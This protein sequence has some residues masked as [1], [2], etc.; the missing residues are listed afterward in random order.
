MPPPI[1]AGGVGRGGAALAST[2][3]QDRGGVRGRTLTKLPPLVPNTPEQA[4]TRQAELDALAAH[5]RARAQQDADRKRQQAAA[6]AAREANRPEVKA[7]RMKANTAIRRKLHRQLKQT[8]DPEGER[9]ITAEIERHK[10]PRARAER[11]R[12]RERNYPNQQ[13]ML[14]KA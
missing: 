1:R 9:R 12:S 10:E 4:E 6:A 7:E 11:N 2:S 13:N 14:R 3:G 5:Y 8:T